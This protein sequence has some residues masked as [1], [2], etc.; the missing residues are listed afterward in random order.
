MS[1]VLVVGAGGHARVV[2]ATLRA[3]GMAVQGVLDDNAAAWGSTVLGCPVLGGLERLEEPGQRAVI[4]IGHNRARQTISLKH[5][6]VEWVSA[7]HPSAV[8]DETARIGAGTVVFA[9][10][11]IQ[12][13]AVLGQHVI[14]NTGA[15]VDHD[16]VLE[17]YVHI[18]PGC[19]LAGTV[20]LGQGA[21][22]GVGSAAVPGVC[23]GAWTT[24]GAGGVVVKDLPAGVVAVGVP[25]KP[26]TQSEGV[27]R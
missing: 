11:V 5:P 19:N 26:R 3:A 21:F 6:E 27:Q 22:L 20:R 4:A 12:P 24:V 25:A 13:N 23:V 2:I 17:D 18:A 9:G 14:V 15:T 1:E 8:V 7:V 16:C 10:A